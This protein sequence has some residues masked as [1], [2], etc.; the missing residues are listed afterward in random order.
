MS[1]KDKTKEELLLE[2]KQL[3]QKYNSLKEFLDEESTE[4][5]R[6]EEALRESEDKYRKAFQSTSDVITITERDGTYIDVNDGFTNLT[7]FTKE[8]VTGKLSTEINIWA[9]PEDLEKLV[10]G[11]KDKGYVENLESKFRRKDGSLITAVISANIIILNNEPHILAIAHDISERKQME[12]LILK[13]KQQYDDLV[14]NIAVGVYILRTKPEGTFALDYVSPR[15][16]EMLNLSIESLI[17]SGEAIFKAIHP[18][19][20][21]GFIRL[22][23]EGIQL[24]RPFDWHGRAIIKG[25]VRWLHITSKPQELES[26]D[27]LWNGLIVDITEQMLAQAEIEH[28]NKELQKINAEKDKF[29]SIIAHDLRSPFNGFLGLTQIMAEELPSLTMAEVQKIAVRMSESAT[30]LY[31]LLT[32][33]LDWSRIQQGAILFKPEVIQLS[34]VIRGS[35]DVIHES[36]KSKKIEIETDIP[37]GLVV[38]ADANMLQTVLRNLISNALKFTPKGGKI[39]VSAKTSDKKSVE[40]SIQDTGIGMSKFLV[41]NLFR[42]DVQT[43]REGTEGEPSTGLGML[44]CKEFVEKHCGRLWVDSEEGNGS[45]FYFTLP[46]LPNRK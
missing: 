46:Y 15:M 43:T 3:Q 14:S 27:I 13:S 18:D 9:I 6:A 30:N 45:T 36:A 16:A 1:D 8:D 44:L 28:Q 33:L 40:I 22:N 4:R 41:T 19:D 2:L 26:G 17:A 12:E 38:F 31:N 42:L 35:I 23:Q 25:V 10:T 20:L 7:G 5:K 29:F 24:K 39:N 32:N 21:E 34:I 37:D 11:L